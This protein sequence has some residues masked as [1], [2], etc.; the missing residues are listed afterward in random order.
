MVAVAAG[1]TRAS[2]ME[3][4]CLL[5]AAAV[6]AGPSRQVAAAIAAALFR[7]ARGESEMECGEDVASRVQLQ[8]AAVEAHDALHKVVGCV[9]HSLGSATLAAQAS[10][11]ITKGGA[12]AIRPLR[13]RANAARRCWSEQPRGEADCQATKTVEIVDE[14]QCFEAN[15]AGG[16]TAAPLLRPSREL[17]AEDSSDA[18]SV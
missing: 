4:A 13:S 9:S 6:R 11:V 12:R 5:L 1:E 3:D 14:E 2:P 10:G 15:A 8:G 16:C 18:K 7:L 17:E